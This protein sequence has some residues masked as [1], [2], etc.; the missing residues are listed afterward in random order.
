MITPNFTNAQ[1]SRF[2]RAIQGDIPSISGG[3]RSG[4][5]ENGGQPLHFA[6]LWPKLRTQVDTAKD[7]IRH[8]FESA[9]NTNSPFT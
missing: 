4:T 6:R 7:V 5:G 8:H 3:Y 1:Y 2:G 9:L